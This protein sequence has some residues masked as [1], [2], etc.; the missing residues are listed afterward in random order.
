MKEQF[1]QDYN[2]H[3]GQYEYNKALS[4]VY[5]HAQVAIRALLHFYTTTLLSFSKPL[6]INSLFAWPA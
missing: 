4:N 6:R 5:Y 2:T 1:G 3:G